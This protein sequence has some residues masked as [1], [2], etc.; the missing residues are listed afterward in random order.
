MGGYRLV[1][2]ETGFCSS[3]RVQFACWKGGWVSGVGAWAAIRHGGVLYGRYFGW[4]GG[5]GVGEWRRGGAAR[6]SREN[7]KKVVNVTVF[8]FTLSQYVFNHCY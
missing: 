6:R 3:A 5:L 2:V 7:T 4:V 1:G 8:F